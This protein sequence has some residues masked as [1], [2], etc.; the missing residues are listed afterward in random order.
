MSRSARG[1]TVATTV[2]RLV[3]GDKRGRSH[4]EKVRRLI[5]QLQ[6]WLSWETVPAKRTRISEEIARLREV[7]SPEERR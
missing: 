1:E 2:D 4:D 3:N 5:R 7:R 6:R